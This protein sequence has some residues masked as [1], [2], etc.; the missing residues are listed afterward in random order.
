MSL[1]LVDNFVGIEKGIALDSAKFEWL[2]KIFDGP[3]FRLNVDEIVNIFAPTHKDNEGFVIGFLN[4]YNFSLK[5][6]FG[7]VFALEYQIAEKLAAFFRT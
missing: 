5:L 6:D 3:F 1:H 4:L 7:L 2:S